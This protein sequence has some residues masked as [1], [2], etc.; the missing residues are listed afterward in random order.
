MQKNDAN[1]EVLFL[2][3][4]TNYA[5]GQWVSSCFVFNRT[6]QSACGGNTGTPQTA[7][8]NQSSIHIKPPKAPKPTGE[9]EVMEAESFFSCPKESCTVNHYKSL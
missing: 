8:F 4:Y 1:D 7:A 6:F 3:F 9:A 2:E 5:K